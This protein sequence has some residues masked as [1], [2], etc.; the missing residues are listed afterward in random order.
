MIDFSCIY[1][2]IYI[3]ITYI[4]MYVCI[5]IYIYIYGIS[6]QFGSLESGITW[7]NLKIFVSFVDFSCMIFWARNILI[8]SN[9][10]LFEAVMEQWYIKNG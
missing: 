8:P 6:G 1:I 4:Y 2:Y 10:I 3:Y 5:Y 9:P 7:Y